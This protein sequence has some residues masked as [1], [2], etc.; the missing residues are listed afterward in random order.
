MSL[1]R[2]K[3][4][5][6]NDE[7]RKQEIM[8]ALQSYL[9]GG[10]AVL[11]YSFDA[12]DFITNG[13]TSN[14]DIYSIIKKIVDKANV[15]T[16]YVY[17]DKE[18]VKS[19]NYLT[20]KYFRD[21]P[22]GAAKHRLEIKKALDFADENLDLVNLLKNPNEVQTWREFITLVRVFY[23]VQGE[24]FIYREA[25]D[26]DCALSL[27][28]IPAQQVLPFIDDGN[29]V[30]WRIN[31]MDGRYR[32]FVGEDMKYILHMKMPNPL[33]D[34]KYSQFRGLS[35]LA[36]GLK[37]L[38]L[39]DAAIESWVKSV[40]NEGAKG[41]ISP[42][43]PN[44]DLWLTPDQVDKTQDTVDKKIH[45]ADNKN[46]I[47]VSAMPLQYTQI[48]LS[49]DALNIVNGIQHAGYKLC[50]LWGVPA[51]LFDP[52]P[53]YQNMKAASERFVKE[54]ILP[55]LSAEEDKLNSWLV[56][57][58]RKRDKRNYLIDYDL[59]AYE[60]LRLSV[61]DTDMFLKTHTINEVR[62]MLGS[63]ELDEEYAN[64]VF[65]QQGLVP[66]SDFDI[67]IQI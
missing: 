31:L 62:V 23:F 48:G 51:T 9:I 3:K 47:V 18:G 11:W 15:A 61:E 8:K 57:P 22:I 7:V 32:D 14:A 64:Q 43:H 28:V 45:G 53:T 40:E 25:G 67:D 55:Y 37:Y 60:E 56:E 30:G 10:G 42:N 6:K 1:F 65:V 16:P 17:I 4:T 36:A 20:T 21:T 26:D 41:L 46:K 35:P 49:P 19:K 29:L 24:A 33:Y 44:P 66:L 38:K 54:V 2:R 50:D 59:S 58:F 13:Y 39:D 52:N 34:N 27:Q 63:D 5:N 12:E